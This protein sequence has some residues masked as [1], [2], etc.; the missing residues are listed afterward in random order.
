MKEFIHLF[1]PVTERLPDRGGYYMWLLKENQQP[2]LRKFI[3]GKIIS[4]IDDQEFPEGWVY[5]NLSH[6]LD[7]STLTTKEAAIQ[8]ANEVGAEYKYRSENWIQ[9]IS[10]LV[11]SKI[12][13]L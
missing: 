4:V 2:M 13:L 1:T 5:E 12:I 6:W 11:N 7:L 8:L 9:E 3:N 10:D